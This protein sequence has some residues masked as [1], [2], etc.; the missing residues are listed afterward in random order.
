MFAVQQIHRKLSWQVDLHDGKRFS[1]HFV[2]FTADKIDCCTSAYHR[3]SPA[4]EVDSVCHLSF[5]VVSGNILATVDSVQQVVS[6]QSALLQ[7]VDQ[8]DYVSI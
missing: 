4:C 5:Q 2:P 8:L 3:S 7:L 1:D 6:Q